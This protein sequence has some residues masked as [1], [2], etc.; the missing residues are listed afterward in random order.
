MPILRFAS[1]VPAC[2]AALLSLAMS[3]MVGCGSAPAH[4][5][6]E[7]PTAPRG[8]LS[9][10]S[11]GPVSWLLLPA[12]WRQLRRV[13]G[14]AEAIGFIERFWAR[15]DPNPR[16]P[17]NPF[18]ETFSRRVEAAD[19][20]YAE[21]GTMGSMTQRGRALIIL[22]SPGGLRISSEP[23]LDWTP[24]PSSKR[25]VSVREVPAEIWTYRIED[26][27]PTLARALAASGSQTEFSMT[28]LKT[29]IR[30]HLVDGE[31]ILDLAVRAAVA[32]PH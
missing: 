29:S 20:L 5:P 28:F 16:E 6:D 12:E 19:L 3:V 25:D 23:S 4:A 22:G 27:P 9:S 14:P 11:S 30:T 10:W 13:D 8:D 15:R 21:E 1:S 31:E 17:G 7:V 2:R 32:A 26:L 18:R 24:S